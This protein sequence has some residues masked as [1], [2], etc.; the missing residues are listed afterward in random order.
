MLEASRAATAATIRIPEGADSFALWLEP[1]A[2]PADAA[3]RLEIQ[4]ASGEATVTLDGLRKNPY[5]ALAVS[6]PSARVPPGAYRARLFLTRTGAAT[7]AAEYR[8]DVRH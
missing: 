7:L 5:G 3:Y 8:F 6:I 1:A 2:S 4:N